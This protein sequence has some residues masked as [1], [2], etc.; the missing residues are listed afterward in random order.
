MGRVTGRTKTRG[1]GK[2]DGRE[3]RRETPRGRAGR[4]ARQKKIQINKS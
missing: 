3:E 2:E 4:G 1:Q